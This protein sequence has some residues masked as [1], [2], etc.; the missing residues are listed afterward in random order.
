MEL[1]KAAVIRAFRTMAQVAV[2]GIPVGAAIQAVDWKT[3]LSIALCS[4]IVSLLTSM[5]GLPEVKGNE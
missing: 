2:G 3:V 5:A 4:G 1:F